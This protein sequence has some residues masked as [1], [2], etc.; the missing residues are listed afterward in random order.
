[1]RWIVLFEDTPE[2]MEHRTQNRPRHV[3]YVNE[4]KSEIVIGGGLKEEPE[5][6]FVGGMWILDVS[7]RER[8]IELIENDP[9][10]NPAYRKYKLLLWG[11][12]LP[13]VPAI[14]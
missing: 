11:K 7:S 4:N 3:A 1:M 13:D 12:I 10:Y 8:A 14:L 5:G 9:Y 2:M 6:I